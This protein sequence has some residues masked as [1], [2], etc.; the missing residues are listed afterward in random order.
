MVLSGATAGAVEVR[1]DTA[2]LRLDDAGRAVALE[3]A[4]TGRNYALPGHPF[5]RIQTDNRRIT[6][7]DTLYQPG[8][9]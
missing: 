1:W 6:L 7:S 4:A 2:V 5:C 8:L 3:D 9:W